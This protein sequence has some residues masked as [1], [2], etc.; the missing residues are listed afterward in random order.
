M[1]SMDAATIRYRKAIKEGLAEYDALHFEEARSLFRRAHE[2]SPARAPS[3]AW[4]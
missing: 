2:I 4:A 3:V 1:V